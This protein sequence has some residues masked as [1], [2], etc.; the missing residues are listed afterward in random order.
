MNR[1]ALCYNAGTAALISDLPPLL[2]LAL[3]RAEMAILEAN[4]TRGQRFAHAFPPQLARD[5][6]L[7]VAYV[8]GHFLNH[9][10]MQMMQGMFRLHDHARVHV[11]GGEREGG[12]GGW[13][14]REVG[15]ERRGE[16]G[17]GSGGCH[18]V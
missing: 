15:G 3:A 8:S 5:R 1:H 7:R 14:V 4:V 6:R 17:R 11:V 18:V 9:P 10:M 13:S 12:G 16:A 2:V